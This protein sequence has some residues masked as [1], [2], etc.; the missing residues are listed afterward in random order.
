[1]ISVRRQSDGAGY[2]MNDDRNSGGGVSES[3]VICCPHCQ[4]VILLQAWR[5]EREEGGG[6]YCRKCSAPV[7]GLCLE[8]MLTHGCEPYIKFI[9]RQV[10]ENYRREQNRK[11]LGII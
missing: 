6:G 11:V 4:T 10:E 8:R 1:M 7:C 2:L 5:K 9:E 3:D